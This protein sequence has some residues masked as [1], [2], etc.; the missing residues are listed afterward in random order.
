MSVCLKNGQHVNRD[1]LLTLAMP[2]SGAHNS[3]VSASNNQLL[4]I[5]EGQTFEVTTKN[6]E[7]FYVRAYSMC[8]VPAI[9]EHEVPDNEIQQIQAVI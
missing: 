2:Y 9:I 7:A 8:R 1:Q 3:I 6:D 5:V 4:E